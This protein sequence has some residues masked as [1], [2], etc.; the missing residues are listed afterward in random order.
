MPSVPR[1]RWYFS[2]NILDKATLLDAYQIYTLKIVVYLLLTSNIPQLSSMIK[3]TSLFFS[4]LLIHHGVAD[5]KKNPLWISHIQIT[6]CHEYI[7]I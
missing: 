2:I 1:S 6:L 7:Y 5:L 3:I 4:I